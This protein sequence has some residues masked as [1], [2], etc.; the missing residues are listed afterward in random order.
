M[1][2][3]MQV[4]SAL[5]KIGLYVQTPPSEKDVKGQWARKSLINPDL[6]VV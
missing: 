6:M 2:A 1:Y 5:F 3:Y 4:Y